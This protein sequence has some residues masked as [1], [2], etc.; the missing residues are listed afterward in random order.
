MTSDAKIGLLLGLLFIFIIAFIINGLPSFREDTDNNELTTNMVNFDNTAL[1]VASRERTAQ[2]ILDWREVVQPQ[3]FDLTRQSS[4]PGG[5][6][7]LPSQD[8]R[9]RS[10]MELPKRPVLAWGP[11]PSAEGQSDA[12][13]PPF[14][15][16]PAVNEGQAE[17]VKP[18]EPALPKVRVYVVKDG[19]NLGSI[20]QKLYGPDEGNKR[21]T[22]TRIFEANR[23]ILTSPDEISV[24]QKLVI[25]PLQ[26]DASDRST[27]R[28]VLSDSLFEKVKSIG[29]K[30]LANQG[31]QVESADVYGQTSGGSYVVREGDNLWKIA[32]D[33]LGSGSRYGE[34]AKLNGDILKDEDTVIAGMRLRMPAR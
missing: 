5:S 1:G 26:T 29:R 2:E 4:V 27:I 33:Q 23:H 21:A 30:H 14:A 31:R 18:T 12:D 32:A 34:I 11:E 6:Q 15:P 20:A 28:D 7:S 9:V 19:D 22:V 25:P 10:V 13:S 16:T 24:G 8:D 3:S 17:Q